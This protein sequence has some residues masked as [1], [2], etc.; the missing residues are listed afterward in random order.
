MNT[1]SGQ[2]CK[3]LREYKNIKK[4]FK[5]QAAKGNYLPKRKNVQNDK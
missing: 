2:T 1:A 5:I 3:E 4:Y